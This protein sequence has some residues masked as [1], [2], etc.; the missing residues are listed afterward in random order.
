ME[1]QFCLTRDTPILE[2]SPYPISALY[3]SAIALG[4]IRTESLTLAGTV[5]SVSLGDGTDTEVSLD[6]SAITLQNG[7]VATGN[8][9]ALTIGSA[10]VTKT[11]TGDL[12]ATDK[13]V[14]RRRSPELIREMLRPRIAAI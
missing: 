9:A 14:L 1:Q 12:T 7:A 3:G 5:A 13:G 11:L 6:G 8:G 10:G 4:S 2:V